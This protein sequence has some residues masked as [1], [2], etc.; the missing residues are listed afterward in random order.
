MKKTLLSLV[1]ASGLFSNAFADEISDMKTQIETLNKKLLSLE[2]QQKRTNKTLSE[3]KQH[4]AFDNVKF[5]IDFRNA[6]DVL[7][8]KD[9]DTGE[10]ATNPSLLTSRLYLTMA[11]SPV[12]KLTFRGKLAIYSI[13]G[14]HAYYDDTTQPSLKDWAAS[15]K[16]TDTL[17]RIKEAYFVYSDSIGEQPISFSIGRRPS[18]N[19][20][21]A[22]YRENEKDE[23][24]PS[25]HTTNIEV[26][27]A[28]VKLDWGRY[29][30]GAYT[31]FVYGRAHTGEINNVYGTGSNPW[32]PYA[33][34][35]SE[36]ENVDFFV[37]PGDA[38]NNGQYELMYQWAHIFNT[39]GKNTATSATKVA[40]GNADLLSLGLKI[41]DTLCFSRHNHL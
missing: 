25:A 10:I 17:M 11:S 29:L 38:Y 20:F 34:T 12:D 3:V 9:N 26:N 40:A 13:W 19:G 6:V 37:M 28:M 23:G 15:S 18:T 36:D 31:K 30:D 39:K 22:N 5:G 33:Q 8:Y 27:G 2:K 32:G 1:V 7:E 4:D 14:A 16:A 41:N 21:L 35:D 24:S